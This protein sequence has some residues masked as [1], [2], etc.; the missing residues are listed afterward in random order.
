[1]VYLENDENEYLKNHLELFQEICHLD[2]SYVITN[3]KTFF[4]KYKIR[5]FYM[6]NK[7]IKLTG[8][9]ILLVNN[10]ITQPDVLYQMIITQD[11]VQ[12]KYVI[13]M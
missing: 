9:E 1:M 2:L 6:K 5:G 3:I 7:V 11:L 4:S 13:N 12:F 8:G 10:L